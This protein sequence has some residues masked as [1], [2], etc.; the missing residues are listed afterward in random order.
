MIS[1]AVPS[2]PE[3]QR[4]PRYR[5][6]QWALKAERNGPANGQILGDSVDEIDDLSSAAVLLDNFRPCVG[7][8]P[9]EAVVW[10]RADVGTVDGKLHEK[11][12][13]VS[14]ADRPRLLAS[15]RSDNCETERRPFCAFEWRQ[16][17]GVNGGGA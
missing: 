15:P 3:T 9:P 16:I 11:E 7:A 1:F 14:L 5:N 6:E 2:H 4:L 13:T 17:L 8:C 12:D 10:D